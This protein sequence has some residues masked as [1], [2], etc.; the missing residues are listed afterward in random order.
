MGDC[1]GTI[2]GE[3]LAPVAEVANAHTPTTKSGPHHDA[4]DLILTNKA[5]PHAIRA[6]TLDGYVG[7]H[8]PVEAVLPLTQPKEHR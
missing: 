8:K 6:K 7:D 2:D 1:N 3:W 5:I 4:I